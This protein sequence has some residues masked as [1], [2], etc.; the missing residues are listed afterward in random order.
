MP[1]DG[2]A[3]S[4]G[5]ATHTGH[6]RQT[7]Q[8]A[9]GAWL[10]AASGPI[11][12]VFVV[13][14]GMGGGHAGEDASALAVQRLVD[15]FAAWSG[16][17]DPNE[18]LHAMKRAVTEL[19][20]EVYDLARSR[21]A[22]QMGTTVDL[23]VVTA[24][25]VLWVHAGDGRIYRL[26]GPSPGPVTDDHSVLS[27]LLK[28]GVD[29][30]TA[31]ATVGGS[32]VTNI[33]GTSH[34]VE[35]DARS[36]E[37]APGQVFA[38]CCDG[39]HGGL[40]KEPP[41]CMAA[42]DMLR[43]T[44]D[45]ASLQT[46]AERVVEEGV[47]RDG[48]DNATCLILRIEPSADAVD[49]P[50]AFQ[51]GQAQVVPPGPAAGPA[52]GPPADAASA[53]REATAAIAAESAP[54]LDGASWGRAGHDADAYRRAMITVFSVFGGCSVLIAGAIVLAVWG[55]WPGSTPRGSKPPPT[56]VEPLPKKVVDL[57]RSLQRLPS[58][59]DLMREG[60]SE[61]RDEATTWSSVA[62]TW[63][64]LE[65]RSQG[66]S[67][68]KDLLQALEREGAT[69][70]EVVSK[71]R[72]RALSLW[73]LSR[74]LAMLRE[75][76]E[77]REVEGPASPAQVLEERD[78]GR[79]RGMIRDLV[80]R[81][82]GPTSGD[83]TKRRLSWWQGPRETRPGSASGADPWRELAWSLSRL[84]SAGGG[85]EAVKLEI[86]ET[87]G[88]RSEIRR[89]IVA[90]MKPLFEKDRRRGAA[91][92]LAGDLADLA[93]RDRAWSDWGSIGKEVEA[94]AR[95]AGTWASLRRDR[96]EEAA[97]EAVGELLTDREARESVGRALRERAFRIWEAH[98]ILEGAAALAPGGGK[99]ARER[100]DAFPERLFTVEEA[101]RLR[102][103]VG[104]LA[105]AWAPA[106]GS[107]RLA[108]RFAWWAK[109]RGRRGR[110]GDSDRRSLL[111]RLGAAR[112][113][114]KRVLEPRSGSDLTAD[115]AATLLEEKMPA[116]AGGGS[117]AT[118]P[119]LLR[120]RVEEA[121]AAVAGA[122]RRR[123]SERIAEARAARADLKKALAEIEETTGADAD[124]ELASEAREKALEKASARARAL[125]ERGAWA[126][127]LPGDKAALEARYEKRRE[128]LA[129]AWKKHLVA[130]INDLPTKKDN[131]PAAPKE[132]LKNI[133]DDLAYASVASTS[134]KTKDA[135][136]DLPND[137]IRKWADYLKERIADIEARLRE[138]SEPEALAELEERAKRLG[139]LLKK[140]R[141]FL[142]EERG[143]ELRA[144]LAVVEEAIGWRTAAVRTAAELEALAASSGEKELG[145]WLAEAAEVVSR[146][147]AAL[148]RGES[149]AERSGDL[150]EA[151]RKAVGALT[152]RL[153]ERVEGADAPPEGDGGA[154]GSLKRELRA[155]RSALEMEESERLAA[156][157]WPASSKERSGG[158]REARAKAFWAGFWKRWPSRS[159]IEIY[160]E[161]EAGLTEGDLPS[162]RIEAL[163]AA[164]PRS[165]RS[166][167]AAWA[168]TY[169]PEE[170][171]PP[172]ATEQVRA[173]T[174]AALEYLEENHRD[175][176]DLVRS[177]G[178]LA[179]ALLL[180]KEKGPNDII[181]PPPKRWVWLPA[182]A[183]AEWSFYARLGQDVG[184]K[185]AY[186]F[187]NVTVSSSAW[188][189]IKEQ[190]LTRPR[191]A[192]GTIDDAIGKGPEDPV[193]WPEKYAWPLWHVEVTSGGYRTLWFGPLP[194]DEEESPANER[195]IGA[196]ETAIEARFGEDA[197]SGATTTFARGGTS[198]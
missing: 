11:R 77:G 24:A 50:P 37:A 179:F 108:E 86:S 141:G 42:D 44:G 103:M 73:E 106:G 178:R 4:F 92:E 177:R 7:N 35:V 56:P 18:L 117:S 115:R 147:R 20:R 88:K 192:W 175:L 39:V 89:D 81:W 1:E 157:S 16:S 140:K 197:I 121:V 64:S 161:D 172:D 110:V 27:G 150:F 137:L 123:A 99:P 33:V 171:S 8:D 95:A 12:G 32:G 166:P 47:R 131:L 34:M 122:W 45:G 194:A 60:W 40:E 67:P 26:D 173:D 58:S 2:L 80:L 19:N 163:R 83:A 196:L 189:M 132:Q 53:P 14:D 187:Q 138:T 111:R 176:A 143:K 62:K 107:G 75:A 152:D 174:D 100:W 164:L 101:K 105:G 129:E 114:A 156:L 130:R 31:R 17:A 23:V 72:N 188:R 160:M 144:R 154:L 96:G 98:K 142:G 146:G 74:V 165:G 195:F 136:Q 182:W 6:E 69:K 65:S 97:T 70:G 87:G 30:E 46:A 48:S 104:A 128:A 145:E 151:L 94:W 57:A 41:Q 116:W 28:Q 91:E 63:A 190:I 168:R 78:R 3:V 148:P 134:E 118:G 139:A 82:A 10:P 52:A 120:G 9:A 90:S 51:S 68:Y 79:L 183:K 29:L 181:Q 126:R 102:G 59:G 193:R 125:G 184:G 124:G 22:G 85:S 15:R 93:G 133:R 66:A 159:E 167:L 135:S 38:L 153:V 36:I 119:A 55:L 54:G 127:L 21:G 186:L 169:V 180:V 162:D 43:Q 5:L 25:H 113:A 185:G 71:L 149:A 198:N 158:S 191:P 84:E 155:L 109:S 76:R 170:K 49:V 112:E 13:A 61:I